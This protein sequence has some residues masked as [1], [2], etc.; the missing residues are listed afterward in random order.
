MVET[1]EANQY[2][3]EC[4]T[5]T[6]WILIDIIETKSLLNNKKPKLIAFLKPLEGKKRLKRV[7]FT[8]LCSQ[9][10]VFLSQDLGSLEKAQMYEKLLKM[11]TDF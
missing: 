6:V 9:Y 5:S 8:D 1:Y 11:K 3:L 4:A 10:S 2:L 7:D